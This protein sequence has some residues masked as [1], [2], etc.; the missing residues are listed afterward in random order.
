MDIK[1]GIVTVI[2]CD[3]CGPDLGARPKSK[4]APLKNL[5]KIV[6]AYNFTPYDIAISY[7]NNVLQ[8]L[9]GRKENER[10]TSAFLGI[11]LDG[12]LY[13]DTLFEEIVWMDEYKCPKGTI[14]R[15]NGACMEISKGQYVT[16]GTI[17][18]PAPMEPYIRHLYVSFRKDMEIEIWCNTIDFRI[19]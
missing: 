9:R 8:K 11:P 19:D 10:C 4:V 3:D 18:G 13:V 2:A 16:K 1:N 5:A 6:K 12:I 17:I 14:L 7:E 15:V